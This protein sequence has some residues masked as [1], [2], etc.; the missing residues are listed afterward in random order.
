MP[1]GNT[2]DFIQFC[3][4]NNLQSVYGSAES[5]KFVHATGGGAHKF[6]DVVKEK[7]G[8]NF[9]K[10]DELTCSII[11]LH[12]VL[13]NAEKEVYT[14][15]TESK[16]HNYLTQASANANA[17]AKKNNHQTTETRDISLKI[18]RC[19][20]THVA[21]GRAAW[22]VSVFAREHRQWREHSSS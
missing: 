20:N 16:Q 4:E 18:Q 12:F 17:N 7:L 19:A 5:L 11:G 6:S 14:I 10:H 21:L 2:V 22:V 3:A 13:F 9:V 1:I 15:D 8:I